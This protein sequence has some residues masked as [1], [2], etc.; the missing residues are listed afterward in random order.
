MIKK[1]IFPVVLLL[2]F[3]VAPSCNSSDETYEETYV[4]STSVQVTGFS[5]A[6]DSKVL[7]SLENVHFSIDLEN[8]QIFN[9]DS[10]PYG[11]NIS[12][13]ITNVTAVSTASAVTLTYKL[14]NG[15]DSVVN[16][17]TNSTDSIDFSNGPVTLNVTSQ[18]G[19][20]SRA[21][22]VKVNVHATKPDTLAWNK[23]ESALMPTNLGR[24]DVQRTVQYQ[25]VCYS[26]SRG[27][28]NSYCL[29]I[30]DNPADVQWE[31]SSISLPFHANVESLH[32]TDDAMWMLSTDGKLYKTTDFAS[33]TATGQTW[34]NIYGAYGSDIVGCATDAAGAYQIVMYPSMKTWQMPAG[35]PV[36][37]TSDAC[38]YKTPMGQ[39]HQLMM[40]GGR[41]AQGNYLNASWSF[42]GTRWANITR[43]ALPKALE[44]VSMV[45]YDLFYVPSSTWRPVQ[46]PAL[47]AFGGVN[48][49][50]INREVYISRDW[51]M[52]WTEAPQFVQLPEDLPSLYG[53]SAIVHTTTLHISRSASGWDA[54]GTRALWP[55]CSFVMPAT[56]SRVTAPITEWECPAIYMFGGYDANGNASNTLWRGVIL[57]YTFNPV[58]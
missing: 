11:T 16:Y 6:N 8:A 26:L 29:A 44:R 53:S 50:G 56:Q 4:A 36:S 24:V 49:S 40:V 12:R 13:L 51:G 39:Y 14:D 1:L 20:V 52:T 7:D 23:L 31:V 45:A 32:A 18:S 5:L 25:D 46:Y 2:G 17:L 33:W 55:Q 47:L 28:N 19:T 48:G 41:D 27:G 30:T 58:Y 37:G 34:N 35:F 3:S 9:A 38:T 22:T 15:A 43:A 42:D 57:R 21:Y 54:L 10:L